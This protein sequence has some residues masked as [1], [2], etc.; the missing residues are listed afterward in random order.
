M[1]ITSA[2]RSIALAALVIVA[3][4]IRTLA[5]SQGPDGQLHPFAPSNYPAYPAPYD[6]SVQ[7][8]A[9]L[10]DQY[11]WSG[12]FDSPSPENTSSRRADHHSS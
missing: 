10:Y 12:K 2:Q 8:A 11:M 1:L 4:A 6:W 5:Q 3:G 9:M 7:W